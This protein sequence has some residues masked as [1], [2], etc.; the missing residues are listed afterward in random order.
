LRNRLAN[1]GWQFGLG[2]EQGNAA[3]SSLNLSPGICAKPAA[4]ASALSKTSPS[5]GRNSMR[6]TCAAPTN[7]STVSIPR[8]RSVRMA[9]TGTSSSVTLVGSA[10]AS[11]TYSDIPWI[12]RIELTFRRFR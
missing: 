8:A 5:N 11:R 7:C 9:S 12:L 4:E 6:A 2:P 1:H 10:N 3:S